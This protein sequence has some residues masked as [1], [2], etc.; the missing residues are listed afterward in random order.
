[1]EGR[2]VTEGGREGGKLKKDIYFY[3]YPT[4][5]NNDNDNGKDNDNDDATVSV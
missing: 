1:V 2:L 4:Q 3:K 5:Y